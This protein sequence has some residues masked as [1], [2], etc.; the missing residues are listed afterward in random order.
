M[1]PKLRNLIQQL[2]EAIHETVADSEHIAAVVHSI[3]D[4]GFDVLVMLEAT[5]GLNEIEA[6]TTE[7][8]AVQNALTSESSG[9][10]TAQDV[11][12]L[13]S[14][15]IR[16]DTDPEGTDPHGFDDDG[17]E[18]TDDIDDGTEDDSKP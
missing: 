15:R 7:P 2:G 4:E 8:K 16:M 11:H 3:R 18:P 13:Q 9:P 17:N 5:I 1:D 6:E 14:L 12:F 10:F